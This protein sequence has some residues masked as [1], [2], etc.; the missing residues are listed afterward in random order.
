MFKKWYTATIIILVHGIKKMKVEG[1]VPG[2]GHILMASS[3]TLFW[4]FFIMSYCIHWFCF[5]SIGGASVPNVLLR[6][7]WMLLSPYAAHCE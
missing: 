4:F 7:W 3:S 5:S 6:I 2:R 1:G